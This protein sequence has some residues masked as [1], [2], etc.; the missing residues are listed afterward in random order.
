MQAVDDPMPLTLADV[1]IRL[2]ER[3]LLS[4][5]AT[6]MPGEVLTVMG[7]S[8][9]GK[10]TLLAFAGGFVDPAFRVSGRILI[11]DRDLTDVPANKR[12]AGILFQDPLLF[13]H[14]S[15]GGNILFAMPQAVKGHKMRRQLAERAL[16]Q[17]GLAG[18]FDRDPETLSGGQKARVALQRTLVSA[19]R[20]LLLD[21]PFSKLD[22]ALRQQTRALVFSKAKAAG[23]PIILVTH[24]G[25]DAE[26]AG[27][28]V[29]EI[30]SEAE[31]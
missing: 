24:D 6:V 16:E 21:E 27:G 19:P 20:Y 15:V 13:P 3:T 4:V 28:R 11:G 22:A 1:T 10:S 26:A 2:A 12:R 14:L 31:A 8:G 30:G 23:V 29:I 17:V 5:S 18:F 9:S 25:A 7:P